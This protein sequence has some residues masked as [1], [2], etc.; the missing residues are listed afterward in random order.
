MPEGHRKRAR[1]VGY[2]QIT[3]LSAAVGFTLPTKDPRS[4]EAITPTMAIVIAT[5]QAV[6]WR[7]DGTDPTAAIG[8][9]LAVN[10]YHTFEGDLANYKFFEQAGGAILNVEYY[11]SDN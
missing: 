3:V 5:A 4:G 1:C 6:R 7:G 10:T 2:Q 9:P 8:M 11:E